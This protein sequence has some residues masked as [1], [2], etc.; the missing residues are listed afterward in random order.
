[1]RYRFIFALTLVSLALLLAACSQGQTTPTTTA[2]TESSGYPPAELNAPA[3]AP[4]DASYPG[5]EIQNQA[6]APDT[7]VDPGYPAPAEGGP[8]LIVYLADGNSVNV[9]RNNLEE[10]PAVTIDAGG[11]QK[12]GPKLSDL[13]TIAG[14]TQYQSITIEGTGNNLTL[15]PAQI[16]DQVILDLSD[17]AQVVLVAGG[18]PADQWVQGVQAVRAK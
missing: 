9:F 1:M 2:P 14:V 18:L 10:L 3:A 4:T 17:T 7:Q 6:P 12:Q 8:A 5:P 15:E 11:Q 16:T 13:L